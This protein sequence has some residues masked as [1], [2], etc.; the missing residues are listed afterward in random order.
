MRAASILFLALLTTTAH[1]D[2]RNKLVP[3]TDILLVDYG[4]V[5]D[6]WAEEGTMYVQLALK[7]G[8]RVKHINTA[9][10]CKSRQFEVD[11]EKW[12]PIGPDTN[13]DAVRE[14][15]CDRKWWHF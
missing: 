14:T 6:P 15:I 5:A 3:G 12:S 10:R 11:R 13:M 9:L 4:K 2:P 8:N 1:A 7:D